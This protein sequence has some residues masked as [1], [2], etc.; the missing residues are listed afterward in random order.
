MHAKAGPRLRFKFSLRTLLILVVFAA[1]LGALHHNVIP[2]IRGCTFRGHTGPISIAEFTPD[3]KRIVTASGK[4]GDQTLRVWDAQTGEQ[5]S[6]RPFH[7]ASRQT[8]VHTAAGPVLVTVGQDDVVPA[9][10]PRSAKF[11]EALTQHVTLKLDE[12][13]L[14]DAIDKINETC[15]PF[16]ST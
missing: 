2:W 9:P 15:R 10:A 7:T 3:G 13:T 4:N 5:L 14:E 12:T 16:L 8:L 11:Q 6:I 1:S